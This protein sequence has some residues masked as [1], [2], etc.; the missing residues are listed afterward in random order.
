MFV[1]PWLS[2]CLILAH[3]VREVFKCFSRIVELYTAGR[4]EVISTAKFFPILL[5][6]VRNSYS[7]L[8]E[9]HVGR[10]GIDSKPAPGPKQKCGRS[11]D[12]KYGERIWPCWLRAQFVDVLSNLGVPFHDRFYKPLD[13]EI[14]VDS[15]SPY[16]VGEC[17]GNVLGGL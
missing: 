5:A 11:L 6:H 8:L 10:W 12:R 1:T 17:K 15:L 14:M 3:I 7:E 2:Y 4:T 16:C 9:L 13:S